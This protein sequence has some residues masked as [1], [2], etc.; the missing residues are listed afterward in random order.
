MLLSASGQQ[1]ISHRGASTDTDTDSDTLWLVRED[2]SADGDAWSRELILLSFLRCY[3]FRLTDFWL[4]TDFT[5][6]HA[7]SRAFRWGEDGIA[8]VSD[9]HGLQ[10]IAFAFW[11]EKELVDNR[12]WLNESLS[13]T[14]SQ[15]L[16]QGASVRSCKS[17]GKSW[18]K[19]QRSPFPLGQHSCEHEFLNLWI[20]T[21]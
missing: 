5:H 21:E 13:L 11:N 15:P 16:P 9:T 2:Y 17:P 1:V 6:D 19:Y 7:R 3:V 20:T 18:R 8:G 10:N 12:K 4:P 14:T